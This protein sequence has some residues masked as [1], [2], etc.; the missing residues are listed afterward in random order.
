V[1][2]TAPPRP[3]RRPSDPVT[4]GE[5]DA[6]VEALIEEARQRGQRRRRRNAAVVTLVALVAGTLFALVGRSA[7][8]QTASPALAARSTL[9]AVT[10][11]SKIAF[12]SEPPGGG[13]CGTVYVMNADGSGQRRLTNGGVAG[14]GQ[15]WG[16]AWSPDGRQIAI[17]SG[18]IQVMNADGSGQRRLSDGGGPAWSPDGRRIAFESN[19]GIDVINADGTEQRL[20]MR[21]AVS[22]PAQLAWSP[23]GEKIAFTIEHPKAPGAQ[24][25]S[26]EIYVVN[27]DGSG[28]RR[29][30]RNTARDNSPVWSPNGRRIAFESNWQLWVMNADGSG[31]QRLT[32][33]GVHN[34]NPAWSPDGKRI[35]F[36]RGR[37]EREVSNGAAGSWGLGLYVMNADGSGEQ[38]LTQG[39]S[40]PYWS[41]DGRE[42]A[43]VSN[44]DGNSDIH[45]M[46]ADGSGRRNLTRAAGRRD[47]QPL[48]SPAQK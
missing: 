10:G 7:Q 33:R 20:L 4:H 13:Y 46:N 24:T 21:A 1:T 38:R 5:F 30:T 42:I 37:R 8:S 18:G 31:K 16:H 17:V 3:P 32:R 45:V 26:L 36:T 15:E 29:L 22:Y 28:Q 11:E 2:L 48:W 41:P 34:F 19:A 44:R 14:C 35:A 12:L 40:Q 25:R 6:L 47:T 23:N 27:P 39:G 43:F 9:S